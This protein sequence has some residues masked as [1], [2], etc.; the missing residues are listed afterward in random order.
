MCEDTHMDLKESAH[1]KHNHSHQV[2]TVLVKRE[3]IAR[4][5]RMEDP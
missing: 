1:N 3:Q 5:A 2:I 4:V